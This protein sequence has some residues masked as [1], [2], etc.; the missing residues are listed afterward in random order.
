MTLL[1]YSIKSAASIETRKTE[2]TK[3]ECQFWKTPVEALQPS[4]ERF[5]DL[6]ED[7]YFWI[8]NP[9]YD[10]SQPRQP[11]CTCGLHMAKT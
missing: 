1:I 10:D 8:L 7:T 6:T 2:R 4:T 3:A 9:V 5:D 11:V